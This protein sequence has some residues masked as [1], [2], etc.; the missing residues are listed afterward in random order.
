MSNGNHW[1]DLDYNG[2]PEEVDWDAGA[3]EQVDAILQQEMEERMARQ[4]KGGR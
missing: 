1:I 4:T 3:D 2:G